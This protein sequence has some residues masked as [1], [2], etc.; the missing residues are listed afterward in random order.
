MATSRV[1]MMASVRV[2]NT[3]AKRDQRKFKK[4]W[5]KKNKSVGDIYKKTGLVYKRFSEANRLQLYVII[6][7]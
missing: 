7:K 1:G 4:P 3:R 2:S 6:S 5:G